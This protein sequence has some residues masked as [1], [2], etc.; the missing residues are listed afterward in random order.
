MKLGVVTGRGALEERVPAWTRRCEVRA[1]NVHLDGVFW[2]PPR[3]HVWRHARVEARARA[4]RVYEAHV[5]M[6]SEQP[7]VASFEHF[8]REVLP[9]VA[10]L[11]YNA[12]QMMAVM[13]HPYYGSFGYQVKRKTQNNS[14]K[15]MFV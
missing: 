11:G 9:Y 10:R 8:R 13:E 1:P 15:T 5:G 4:L 3:A 12:V 7:R 6:S 2:E 14:Q